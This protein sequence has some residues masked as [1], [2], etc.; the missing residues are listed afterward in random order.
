[1]GS[2]RG[3]Q[4]AYQSGVAPHGSSSSGS[5]PSFRKSATA[6]DRFG[7]VVEVLCEDQF[8]TV[9]EHLDGGVALLI[10]DEFQ[11]ASTMTAAIVLGTAVRQSLPSKG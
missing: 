11:H 2:G 1:M 9:A 10:G 3:A 6:E 8:V 7:D 4:A 5:S